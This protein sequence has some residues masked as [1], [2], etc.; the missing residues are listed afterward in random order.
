VTVNLGGTPTN[1]L[2][3]AFERRVLTYT[4]SN[5][6]GWRVEAA[7]VGRHYYQWRY[8]TTGGEP[9]EAVGVKVTRDLSGNWMFLGEVTN[10]SRAAYGDVEVRVELLYNTGEVVGEYSA[11]VD[12]SLIQAGESFPFQVWTD[13]GARFADYRIEVRARPS[14]HFTRP[15]MELVEHSADWASPI[16]FDISGTVLSHSDEAIPFPQFVVALYDDHGNV[17]AYQWG[18]IDPLSLSARGEARIQT[19]FIDPPRFSSYRSFV[20]D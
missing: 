8:L 7:N 16:R 9:V 14:H 2:V 15:P 10:H 13:T 5:A 20:S 6:S 1:V 18:M 4:P 17:V 11:Y 3:Q 12:T 19:F